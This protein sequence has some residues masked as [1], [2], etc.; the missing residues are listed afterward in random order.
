MRIE[1]E[2]ES[3]KDIEEEEEEEEDDVGPLRSHG[4]VKVNL[5]W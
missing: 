2:S 3:I 4:Q 1:L 5:P